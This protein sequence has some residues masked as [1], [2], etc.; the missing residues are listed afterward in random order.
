MTDIQLNAEQQL[1]EKGISEWYLSGSH[2]HV[3]LSGYPGTGKTFTLAYVLEKLQPSFHSFCV[4]APS[5]KAKRVI[6]GY[7]SE[8]GLAYPVFTVHSL[9]GLGAEISETG[10]QTFDKSS[11]KAP[12]QK[13]RY[14]WA[15]E[16]SMIPADLFDKLITS[17]V[18]LIFTGDENQLKP[19]NE[20]SFAAFDYFKSRPEHHFKLT[21]PERYSGDIKDFVYEALRCVQNKTLF[22]PENHLPYSEVCSSM[23]DWFSHWKNNSNDKVVLAYTN[24][25]VDTIN[26][27]CREFIYGI[28]AE[29]YVINETLLTYAP[30]EDDEGGMLIPNGTE[31]IV[32]GYEASVILGY[33]TTFE[34][35]KVYCRGYDYPFQVVQNHEKKAWAKYLDKIKKECVS[36]KA[37]WYEYYSAKALSA[38]VK[39][40]YGLTIHKS[41]GSGYDD[42]YMLNDFNWMKD[43]DGQPRLHYVGAS[44]AKQRLFY[45][46]KA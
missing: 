36:G 34:A 45:T 41:Q 13:F 32:E 3:L 33:S 26:Q 30:I 20:D 19:V 29:E 17:H 16:C 8:L 42:V 15:D 10:K 39:P 28:D 5:H 46:K 12:I 31:V 37:R 1:A 27:R 25:S 6:E 40:T 24:N 23:R 7:L 43:R 44:R 11:G 35:W 9:L 18:K 38:E 2:Y 4:C 14:V 22:V 21:N